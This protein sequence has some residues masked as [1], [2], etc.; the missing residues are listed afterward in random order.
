MINDGTQLKVKTAVLIPMG[1]E[2]RNGRFHSFAGKNWNEEHFA[3]VFGDLPSDSVPVIRIHSECLTGDVFGSQ[4]CDC[5]PQL[6]EAVDI[7][8]REGGVLLYLRQEGRGIGLYS[9]FEAYRLQDMG[10]DTFEANTQLNLPEDDRD[11]SDAVKMLEALEITQCRIITNNPD[12]VATLRKMGIDVV[13]IIPTGVYIT[14]HNHSYLKS[15]ADKK[16][17]SIAL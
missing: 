1:P 2:N 3:V 5:G 13:E 8:S 9:K 17:H 16:K 14:E 6:N 10:F 7:I 12:K 15:K 4:R 11:F